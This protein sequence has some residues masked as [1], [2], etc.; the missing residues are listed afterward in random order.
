MWIFAWLVTGVFCGLL[1][2]RVL[3]SEGPSV[4]IAFGIVGA[5][6]GGLLFNHTAGAAALARFDLSSLPAALMGAA[7]ILLLNRLLVRNQPH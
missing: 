5:L 4:D 1:T 3:P 7:V 2:H 6:L